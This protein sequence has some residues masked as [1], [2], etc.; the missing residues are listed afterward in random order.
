MTITKLKKQTKK[1]KKEKEPIQDQ[2][3]EAE[4]VPATTA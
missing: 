2:H 4:R 1:N 3:K